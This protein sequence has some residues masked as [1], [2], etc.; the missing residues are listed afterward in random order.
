MTSTN[1]PKA[2]PYGCQWCGD[3]Q[4]HHGHQWHPAAGL[5]QWTKPTQ[6]QI[7]DRMQARRAGRSQPARLLDC[8]LCFEEEGE[9]VHP[10]PECTA[11]AVPAA[12]VGGEPGTNQ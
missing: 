9:E 8:G 4:H 2:A 12:V 3:E 10:H 11:A 7:R 5:H 6:D 1:D